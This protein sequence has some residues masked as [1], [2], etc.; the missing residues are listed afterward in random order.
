MGG[1]QYFCPSLEKIF[2]KFFDFF[3]KSIDKS[4]GI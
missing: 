2:E 3:S 1:G 4:R